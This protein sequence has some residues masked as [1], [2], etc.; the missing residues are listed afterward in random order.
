MSHTPKL[1]WLG[2]PCHREG[3][4][5]LLLTHSKELLEADVE[6]RGPP[7][8]HQEAGAPDRPHCP[9]ALRVTEPARQAVG[10]CC[11]K[12]VGHPV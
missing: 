4:A 1:H 10:K 5:V 6:G 2:Q 11:A 9:L 3:V 12:A 8:R 7:A